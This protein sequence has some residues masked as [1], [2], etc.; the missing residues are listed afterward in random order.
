MQ[1]LVPE[2]SKVSFSSFDDILS[3]LDDLEA[4]P[5]QQKATI[6]KRDPETPLSPEIGNSN[7]C[8]VCN[9]RIFADKLMTE[10]RN[11]HPSC[12]TCFNCGVNLSRNYFNR[13]GVNY[14][15]TC[16][17][18]SNPCK[19]CGKA[20]TA[21]SKYSIDGSGNNHHIDCVSQQKIC[22]RCNKAVISVEVK[23]LEKVFHPDCFKCAECDCLLEGTFVNVNGNAVCRACRSNVKPKCDACFLPLVK[24]YTEYKGKMFHGSCFA[25]A[26]CKKEIGQTPFYDVGGKPVCQTCDIWKK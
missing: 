8:H 17:E 2:L 20:I 4:K 21:G 19:T 3:T 7:T 26:Q 14:C 23:A 10:G 9:K 25:C 18:S 12:F 13:S 24:D 5:I 15:V 11:Y 22:N 1:R 6:K 16:V